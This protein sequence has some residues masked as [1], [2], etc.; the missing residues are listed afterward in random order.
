MNS[1][2]CSGTELTLILAGFAA[3]GWAAVLGSELPATP[4]AY[5]K[6]PSPISRSVR[7]SRQTDLLARWARQAPYYC[8]C[9]DTYSDQPGHPK[10]KR[11]IAARGMSVRRVATAPTN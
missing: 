4:A 6:R 5:T 9:C 10:P 11:R 2:R 3:L 8:S 1:M 7:L